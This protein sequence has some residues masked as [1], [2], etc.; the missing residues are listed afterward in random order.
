MVLTYARCQIPV[1]RANGYADPTAFAVQSNTRTMPCL[2]AFDVRQ[3]F[4]ELSV[5]DLRYS[6]MELRIITIEYSRQQS[7]K[8]HVAGATDKLTVW[9]VPLRG[10]SRARR[11]QRQVSVQPS[12]PLLSPG[13]HSSR[14]RCP[15]RQPADF[16]AIRGGFRHKLVRRPSADSALSAKE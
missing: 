12:R 1:P 14:P 11:S 8:V 13:R 5:A 7:E 9:Q 4:R 3:R 6:Y 10:R 16:L 15:S 2:V